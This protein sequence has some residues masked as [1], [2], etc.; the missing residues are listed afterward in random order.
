MHGGFAIILAY[1]ATYVYASPIS[2]SSRR[3]LSDLGSLPGCA[4]PC[5]TAP[6]LGC[7]SNDAECLCTHPEF[8]TNTASCAAQDCQGN[9]LQLA[10]EALEGFCM[11]GGAALNATSVSSLA[12][13]DASEILYDPSSTTTLPAITTSGGATKA[14]SAPASTTM[15]SA[16]SSKATGTGTSKAKTKNAA[17]SNSMVTYEIFGLFGAGVGVIGAALLVI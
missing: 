4:L 5:A 8:V 14:T 17:L 16:S 9:D 1:V 13:A 3:Q 10:V 2:T 12:T 11:A 7:T 15:T 6:F